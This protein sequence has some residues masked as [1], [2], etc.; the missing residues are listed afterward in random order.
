MDR[1]PNESE[2][3]YQAYRMFVEAGIG[4]SAREVGRRLGKDWSLISRWSSGHRW[5]ERARAFDARLQHVAHK[6][7]EEMI[8]ASA[9]RW[10]KR[11]EETREEAF[12]VAEELI[13]KARA[14]LK[15]PISESTSVDGKTVVKPGRWSFADAARMADTAAKLKAMA[16]GLPSEHGDASG[17]AVTRT[18]IAAVSVTEIQATVF[19]QMRRELLA[20]TRRHKTI[21]EKEVTD[22]TPGE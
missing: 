15:F 20:E 22:A 13:A 12:Q 14:M 10:A 21:D 18:E 6:A 9:G 19:D 2:P 11:M 5:L 3:A 8:I 7:E 4:R 16:T 17:P 1:L